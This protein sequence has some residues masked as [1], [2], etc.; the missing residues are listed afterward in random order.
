MTH[1][2]YSELKTVLSLDACREFSVF[3]ALSDDSIE[4]LLSHGDCIE[5]SKHE[6]LY[7]T[8]DPSNGFY[9]VLSGLLAFYK[10]HQGHSCLVRQYAPG[11]ELGFVGMIS[12]HPRAG[13][14]QMHEAGRVLRVSD[15][16]FHQLQQRNGHDF[17]L[18]L[19]NLV[20]DKSRELTN[21]NNMLVDMSAGLENPVNKSDKDQA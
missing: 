10:E 2:D 16:I 19:I 4:F 20:R 7:H 17:T 3:G 13:W 1:L 6:M 12:L 15:A 18:L 14:A 21:A 8:G 5:L 11:E 9:V